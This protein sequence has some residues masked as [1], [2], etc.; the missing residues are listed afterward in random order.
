MPRIMQVSLNINPVLMFFALVI[1][2]KIAALLGV[3]LAVPI[4]RIAI[5]LF[6]MDELKAD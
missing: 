4:A 6:E 3:F 5:S 1:G 2:A